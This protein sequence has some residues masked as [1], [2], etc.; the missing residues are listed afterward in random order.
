LKYASTQRRRS[1]TILLAK[2]VEQVKFAASKEATC[3]VANLVVA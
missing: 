2:F 1:E 3:T